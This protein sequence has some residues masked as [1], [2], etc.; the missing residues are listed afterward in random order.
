MIV[1]PEE[2]CN[3]FWLNFLDIFTASGELTVTLYNADVSPVFGT[4]FAS[5]TPAD[6]DGSGPLAAETWAIEGSHDPIVRGQMTTDLIWTVTGGTNLPQT[7]YGYFVTSATFG[8]LWC[9]RAGT[10]I[11]LTTVGQQ[12]AL[13]PSFDFGNCP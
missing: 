1:I 10:P 4:S 2:G 6:F 12:V 13:R 5:L 7:I 8:N 3:D 9:E 11:V